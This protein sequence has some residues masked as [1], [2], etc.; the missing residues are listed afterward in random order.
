MGS[1]PTLSAT[2][3]FK[4][5]RSEYGREVFEE[6]HPSIR[7]KYTCEIKPGRFCVN[8]N[9][10]K[11]VRF[12]QHDI[13]RSKPPA[14]NFDLILCRNVLIYFTA[15]HQEI[16]FR[17]FFEALSRNGIMMLGRTEILPYHLRN[18]FTCLDTKHRFY[19]KSA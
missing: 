11:L 14:K 15:D 3:F 10:K 6:V 8:P 2:D 16:V 18:R 13:L 17:E 5:I 7:K 9:V 12:K 4:T 1:N 19:Q